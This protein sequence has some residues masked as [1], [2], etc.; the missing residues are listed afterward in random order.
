MMPAV[1]ARR[2]GGAPPGGAARASRPDR[3]CAFGASSPARTARERSEIAPHSHSAAA[4]P[5]SGISAGVA[6][7]VSRCRSMFGVHCWSGMSPA[8]SRITQSPRASATPRDQASP[9]FAL[10]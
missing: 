3:I 2:A 6:A 7:A 9:F 4:T 5:R 10:T 8:S 1:R